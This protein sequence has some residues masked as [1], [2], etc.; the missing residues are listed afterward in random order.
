[1]VGKGSV[2]HNSRLFNAQ[3][4]DPERTHLNT[5]LCNEN[6]KDVYIEL[7]E[8]ARLK[9]NEKQKRADRTIDNY[10][11]KIRS[12][13][14]EKL[15]HEIILQIGDKDNMSSHSDN[16]LLAEKIMKEYYQNFQQRNPY[17]RVFSAHIHMDEATPHIHID[18]VPFTTDS[19]RGME[20]RVSLKQAL[21]K[22]GFTGKGKSENEWNQWVLSEKQQ[23]A[24]IMGKYN[25]EWEQKG[26]HDKHLSVL[27][28]EK[29]MRAQEVKQL[30]SD[31][32]EKTDTVKLL[33]KEINE[34]KNCN[35]A[36]RD[37]E[38]Q[39]ET[40][41][42]YIL[43]EPQKLMSAK[44]YKEKFVLPV[45]DAL[46][47]MIKYLTVRYFEANNDYHR[48]NQLNGKLYQENRYLRD[49]I[50]DLSQENDLLRKENKDY[51][52]LRKVF[53]NKQIDNLLQQARQLKTK[54]KQQ[55]R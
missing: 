2:N 31:I 50:N 3:N 17:L 33:E 30:E 5:C 36:V 28:F 45:V 48:V 21:A 38:K 18:F 12:S 39:F 27:E 55:Q 6:I 32:S 23:M 51:R 25:I 41:P 44:T 43:A 20:T 46:K 22:Q 13:K 4:T 7:F 26:T 24:K 16:G 11:E 53:G 37:I 1:M 34:Y 54:D 52:L 10:Y 19:K 14:Q 47:K 35:I 8:D 29:K 9:Y 49:K 42:Q 40:D 15:F